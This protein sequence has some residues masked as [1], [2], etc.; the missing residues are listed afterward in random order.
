MFGQPHSE[1]HCRKK[2]L[3]TGVRRELVD[4]TRQEHDGSLRRA[5]RLIGISDSSYRYQPVVGKDN[6]VIAEIQAAVE[7]YPAYGFGNYAA[8]KSMMG[9]KR[10]DAN[11][12]EFKHSGNYD[13]QFIFKDDNN[14]PYANHRYY[15]WNESGQ[16]FTGTTDD[17]GQTAVYKMP[18]P[19]KNFARLIVQSEQSDG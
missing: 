13:I 4:Y 6:A 16:E 12:P 18:T 5:C 15:V 9:P 17:K 11:L 8:T 10:L 1:R 7:R 19:D 3:T 2:A 14:V